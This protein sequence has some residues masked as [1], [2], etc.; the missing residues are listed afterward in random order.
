MIEGKSLDELG[1][2]M[3]EI[4][5]TFSADRTMGSGT[6]ILVKFSLKNR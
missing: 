5:A 2:L 6:L 4:E 1:E 3:K